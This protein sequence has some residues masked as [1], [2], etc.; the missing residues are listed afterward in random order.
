MKRTRCARIWRA[1]SLFFRTRSLGGESCES[2]PIKARLLNEPLASRYE[3]IS[4]AE[5]L[6]L[7]LS[8][9][10]KGSPGGLEAVS[11]LCV[12]CPDAP[13]ARLCAGKHKL[14]TSGHDFQ[15]GSI[16]GQI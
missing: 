3:P 4:L 15:G 12:H 5:F 14:V 10:N 1:R 9:I 11:T 13:A 16:C 6:P 8:K 2:G 7:A